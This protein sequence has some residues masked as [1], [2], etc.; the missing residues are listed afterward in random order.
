[1]SCCQWLARLV[2]IGRTKLKKSFRCESAVAYA[3][4]GG[5]SFCFAHLSQLM[6]PADGNECNDDDDD[7]DDDD[8]EAVSAALT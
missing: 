2:P 4:N 3:S 7:N 5:G 8:H 6:L 1:M